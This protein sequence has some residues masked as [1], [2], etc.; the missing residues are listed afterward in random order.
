LLLVAEDL[1]RVRRFLELV[2]GG[3]VLG[4]LVGMKLLRE[5]SIRLLQIGLA[6]AS[7]DPEHFIQITH[8]RRES[9]P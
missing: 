4:V 2:L 6:R 8:V 9:R 7:L 5:A 1:V 3:F